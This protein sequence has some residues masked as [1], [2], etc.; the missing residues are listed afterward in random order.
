MLEVA[1]PDFKKAA[2]DAFVE[3]PNPGIPSGKGGEGGLDREHGVFTETVENGIQLL[4]I[5]I[6]EIALFNHI[7]HLLSG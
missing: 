1:V 4:L 5:D 3:I 2:T 6:A 7:N